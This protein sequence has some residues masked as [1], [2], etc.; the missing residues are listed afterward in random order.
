MNIASI[1]D[2]DVVISVSSLKR[3][4]ITMLFSVPWLRPEVFAPLDSYCFGT[5]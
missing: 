3:M 5:S 2:S 4:N 1:V